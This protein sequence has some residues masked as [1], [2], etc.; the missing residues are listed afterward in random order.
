MFQDLIPTAV[1]ADAAG[2]SVYLAG[3]QPNPDEPSI[4]VQKLA[5]SGSSLIYSTTLGGGGG[6]V[7]GLGIDGAGDAF[8]TGVPPEDF[9][10]VNPIDDVSV[11]KAFLAELD[12]TG[13]IAYSTFQPLGG[14]RFG[15][16]VDAAGNAYIAGT[17][18]NQDLEFGYANYVANSRLVK[19][20]PGNTGTANK[21][22]V[23]DPVF[24]AN[25]TASSV[26]VLVG[27][28]GDLTGPATV[29]YTASGGT[30][31]PG[32]EY[33]AGSG[34][35]TFG[36]GEE[37]KAARISLIASPEDVVKGD[38]TFN[39]SVAPAVPGSGTATVDI[40]YP[41]LPPAPVE[42]PIVTT[43]DVR[44]TAQSNVPWARVVPP[45][46][47]GSATPYVY[48]DPNQIPPAG[49]YVIHIAWTDQSGGGATG[50]GYGTDITVVIEDYP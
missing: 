3:P 50:S 37:V 46:G 22:F 40:C 27:R 32:V 12:P 48:L 33:V 28:T 25:G 15:F 1:A 10:L 16:W 41:K 29:D 34:T 31:L 8:V 5:S 11:G 13:A 21:F 7:E 4:Y 17:E 49:T 2:A 39:V 20:A 35:V 38:F 47:S 6:S 42:L 24:Y 19:I 45:L 9:P 23:Y 14:Y 30:A 36:P 44:W 18:A 26:D 43:P